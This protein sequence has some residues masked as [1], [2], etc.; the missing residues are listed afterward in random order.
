LDL[1]REAEEQA[2]GAV[3]PGVGLLQLV[4]CCC[5]HPHRLRERAK[6]REPSAYSDGGQSSWKS[7]LSAHG[8]DA[9]ADT[10]PG[11]IRFL[12]SRNL[13]S[14]AGSRGDLMK[15][16]SGQISTRRPMRRAP[17][18]VTK[19]NADERPVSITDEPRRR[20][21]WVVPVLGRAR[22]TRCIAGGDSPRHQELP[23]H[24]PQARELRRPR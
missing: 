13:I 10:E 9:I 1:C 15:H 12:Q 20:K 6:R 5:F 23:A 21:C 18:V 16:A 14:L 3:P 22:L 17:I 2:S 11:P 19:P 7:P 8:I 4:C 24:R